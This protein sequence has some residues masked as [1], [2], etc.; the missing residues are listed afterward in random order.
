MRGI[1]KCAHD[2]DLAE[3]LIEPVLQNRRVV[4]G[5]VGEASFGKPLLPRQDRKPGGGR[6]DDPKAAGDK[7]GPKMDTSRPSRLDKSGMRASGS[8]GA[9][10][11]KPANAIN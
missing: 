9:A 2:K 11:S 3:I 8:L 1:V 4:S 5:D 10:L 6:D 7:N